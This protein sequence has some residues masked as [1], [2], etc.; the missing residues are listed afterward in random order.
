M[1]L[2]VYRENVAE[3]V[4]MTAKYAIRD[5]MSGDPESIEW[6]DAMIP[7]WR[8]HYQPPAPTAKE[9]AGG[10]TMISG[11][12]V[13]WCGNGFTPKRRGQK[14]CSD[15]CRIMFHRKGMSV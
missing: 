14:F 2:D 12:N 1:Q 3:L 13:C 15:L 10:V 6:L 5:A 9:Q 7:E 11:S 4:A 8:K